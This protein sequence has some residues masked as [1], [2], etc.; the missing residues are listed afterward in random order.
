MRAIRNTVE[1]LL[2]D[3]AAVS[4][5]EGAIPLSGAPRIRRVIVPP[6]QEQQQNEDA[7]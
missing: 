3:S 2:A 7:G 4:A 1:L 6:D 5:D